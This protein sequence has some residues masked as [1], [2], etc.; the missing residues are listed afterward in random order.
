MEQEI[1]P[2][3]LQALMDSGEVQ[4]LSQ[5]QELTS[6][7][8]DAMVRRGEVSDV[9][10]PDDS[11]LNKIGRGA[12]RA[13]QFLVEDVLAPVGT[14]LD[15]YGGG[16]SARAFIGELQTPGK[17][18][19]DA[20]AAAYEQYGKKPS[21]APSG[22]QIMK[23]AGVPDTAL[24]DVF[25]GMYSESGEG[26]AFQRGGMFDPTAS[27]A[28]GFGVEVLADP[29]NL[30]PGVA[31]AKGA[32]AGGKVAGQAA[33]II[34][35]EGG[36]A[37][38]VGAGKLAG[39]TIDTFKKAAVGTGQAI[40][41]AAD[42]ATGVGKGESTISK[43]VNAVIDSY[44]GKLSKAVD[45]NLDIAARIGLDPADL[46]ASI[47][48]DGAIPR[49]ERSIA[50]GPTGGE[51]LRKIDDFYDALDTKAIQKVEEIAWA[52]KSTLT[53]EAV[54]DFMV[55]SVEN[56][57]GNL[58]KNN[59]VRYSTII[60]NPKK[61]IN[62]STTASN[63]LLNSLENLKSRATKMM[64]IQDP[65]MQAQAARL[66]QNINGIQD[67]ANMGGKTQVGMFNRPDLDFFVE[68]MK[69]IR[70]VAYPTKSAQSVIQ[71][72]PDM[73]K[74]YQ[75]M[76]RA[77]N[78]SVIDSVF[79]HDRKLGQELLKSNEAITKFSRDV[80]P[81]N[82]LIGGGRV[83]GSALFN[84]IKG[85]AKKIEALK[86]V[87]TPNEFKKIKGSLVQDIL[88]IN[89]ENQLVYSA[90]KKGFD[91]KKTLLSKFLSKKEMAD[92]EDILHLGV[93][94][95]GRIGSLPQTGA[96]VKFSD[97]ARQTL[98]D[99]NNRVMLDNLKKSA[100][101]GNVR[102]SRIYGHK[103]IAQEALEKAKPQKSGLYSIEL[104][105][106]TIDE[107]LKDFVKE[108]TSKEFMGVKALEQ[109]KDTEE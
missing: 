30:I 28:A 47:V 84:T 78:K 67:Y 52:P 72:T 109:F 50:M 26:L 86:N 92:L 96:T 104:P 13:G 55:D 70:E 49:F 15:Q 18:L 17:D 85:D 22:P 98:K 105:K 57:T 14:A 39:K 35:K 87:M 42:I 58:F 41:S 10:Q 6:E 9:M 103:E 56:A 77:L 66:L 20:G 43:S 76:Y 48:F 46:P 5:E 1:T 23:R 12:K 29:L 54:G 107:F 45:K 90:S 61:P 82:K 69:A 99:V 97:G 74:T 53:P 102:A 89:A 60:N 100:S 8:V 2:E 19:V 106:T 59:E 95:E 108:K 4:D 21:I 83:S 80:E 25:P 3:E 93:Q 64:K 101:T 62:L 33:K 32:K 31:I 38:I 73:Q 88:N 81:I 27:G 7:E 71:V 65:T 63:R 16:A 37:A 94:G 24:S 75:E 44:K 51:F 40:G 34:G 91:S 79:S 36:R 68:N 11:I